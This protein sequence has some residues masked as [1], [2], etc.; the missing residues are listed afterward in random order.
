MIVNIIVAY[1]KNRGLGKNNTLLWDVKSDMAKFKKLTSGDGNNAI[2]MGRKTFESLN[3]SKGLV[4]RD[5]LILSK[6][7][8]LDNY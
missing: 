5:N 1:C 4:A 8:L 7:L 3:N 6:S 2:I